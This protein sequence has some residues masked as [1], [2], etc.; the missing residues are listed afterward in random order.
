MLG[1]I[2]DSKV[3]KESLN[4]AEA[5]RKEPNGC[6]SSVHCSV[7]Q[8]RL[9][10]SS[11]NWNEKMTEDYKHIFSVLWSPFIAQ[12]CTNPVTFF[13]KG[14]VDSLIQHLHVDSYVKIH[15][16][17]PDCTSS[18]FSF[19]LFFLPLLFCLFS[20]LPFISKF[21]LIQRRTKLYLSL[22]LQIVN[23]YIGHWLASYLIR[24]SRVSQ[25]TSA[26]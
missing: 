9:S 23:P 12:F 3:S 7:S 11:L 25:N 5:P 15:L 6:S 4:A 8:Q 26:E 19:T 24:L 1:G 22:F 18:S 2:S 13:I 14:F 21:C 16:F 20:T 10:T 17:L